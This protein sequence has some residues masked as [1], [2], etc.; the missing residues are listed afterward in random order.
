MSESSPADLSGLLRQAQ[1][2]SEQLARA[3]ARADDEVVEGSAGG[4]L[5]RVVVSGA[6]EFRSVSIDPAAVDPDDLELLGDLVVAA[7]S[8]A[9]AQVRQLRSQTLGELAPEL[10]GGLLDAE[11]AP[12]ADQPPA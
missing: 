12:D 11:P 3:Q 7:L 9:M 4:G 6:L 8:D 5:V 2:L 1:Q 10:M